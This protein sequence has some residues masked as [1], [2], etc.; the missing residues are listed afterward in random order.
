MKV[1]VLPLRII[2]AE[3]PWTVQ[4]EF[5]IHPLGG[6]NFKDPVFRRCSSLQFRCR[7]ALNIL[8]LQLVRV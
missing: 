2:S 5:V 8:R 6:A 4:K 7:I 3:F 1:G